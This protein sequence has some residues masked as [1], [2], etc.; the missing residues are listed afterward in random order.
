MRKTAMAVITVATAA[1]LAG[2]GGGDKGDDKGDKAASASQGSE[3]RPK[4]DTD[5]GTS[6]QVTLEV[7]GKGT[8]QIYYN[9]DGNG[10]QQVTLPWKRTATITPEGA[11]RTVGRLVSVVPGSSQDENGMLRAGSCTIVVDGK[12]V[13]DNQDGKSNKPCEYKVK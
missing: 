5:K 8:T 10:A 1:L 13:A 12:K 6:H 4:E 9:L 11:E 2:C 3:A 7:R